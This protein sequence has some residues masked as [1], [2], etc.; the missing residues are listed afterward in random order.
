MNNQARK[1]VSDLLDTMPAGLVPFK[2]PVHR[3]KEE[4]GQDGRINV[5]IALAALLALSEELN[6]I[7]FVFVANA[8]TRGTNFRGHVRKDPDVCR[9]KA[10]VAEKALN[11]RSDR[12]T[13]Y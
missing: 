9:G 4:V 7:A 8:E 5:W 13:K 10:V 11:V 3:A 2:S 1:I 12:G 6:P